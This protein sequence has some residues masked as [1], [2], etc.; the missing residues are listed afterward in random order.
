MFQFHRMQLVR[1]SMNFRRQSLHLRREFLHPSANLLAVRRRGFSK[2][3]QLDGKH[4]EA[5]A[6]VIMQFTRQPHLLLFLR[7]DEPPAQIAR[8]F[9]GEPKPVMSMAEP[10]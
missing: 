5:L 4:R 2:H 6:Q 10:I 1:E 7:L 8:G 9:L 3:L